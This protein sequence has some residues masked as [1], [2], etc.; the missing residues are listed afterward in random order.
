LPSGAGLLPSTVYCL[1]R[2]ATSLLHDF[3]SSSLR[4]D[5]I[6]FNSAITAAGEAQAWH[7][8]TWKPLMKNHLPSI[9]KIHEHLIKI[10][11]AWENDLPIIKNK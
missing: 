10:C 7:S 2:G 9:G 5:V 3:A 11:I 8:A 6:A 1:P 4:A